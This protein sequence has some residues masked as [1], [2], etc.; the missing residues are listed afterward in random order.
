MQGGSASLENIG[1]SDVKYIQE[2]KRLAVLIAAAGIAGCTGST[3]PESATLFDNINNLN[4]GEYD[5]QISANQ[6][7]ADA[8]L[9]N[10]QAAEKRITNLESQRAANSGA[11]SRLKAQAASTRQTALNARSRVAGDSVKSAQLSSLESQLASVS[12]EINAGSADSGIAS[13]EL[14]RINRAIAAL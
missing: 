8:I 2:C 10:N 3:N 7:Q 13:A 1:K 12:S 4:S 11:I 14:R 5:R 9:R 6:A